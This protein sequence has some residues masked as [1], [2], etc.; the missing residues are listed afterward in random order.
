MK[1]RLVE[2]V[3]KA[4]DEQKYLTSDKSIN[5]IADYLLEN[6]VI[7]PLCKVGDKVYYVSKNPFCLSVQANTIY[8]AEVVRI[9]TTNME[10][11]LVIQIHNDYG[12]TEITNIHEWQ[13]VV[14]PTREQAEAKLKEGAE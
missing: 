4:H 3:K 5:A 12:C 2:L 9:V 11:S 7:V 14:F 8:E 10:T 13:Q 6:G 1:E